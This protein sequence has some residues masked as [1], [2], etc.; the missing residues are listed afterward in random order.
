MSRAGLVIL[1][2]LLAPTLGADE[3][4]PGAPP[5][6]PRIAVEPA[7]FDFGRARPNK[8]L[9]KEFNIRNFAAEDLVVEGTSTTCGCTAALLESK[10]IKPGGSTPLRVTLETRSARGR[11]VRSVLIRSNDPARSPFEVKLEA[12]VIPEAK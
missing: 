9:Q 10:V 7:S 2:L 5:R 8:T 12:T 3:A 11:V 1:S 6:G 4:R